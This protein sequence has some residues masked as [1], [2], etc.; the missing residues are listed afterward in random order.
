MTTIYLGQRDGRTPDEDHD[1]HPAPPSS[2]YTAKV[3]TIGHDYGRSLIDTADTS[4]TK[5]PYKSELG[6]G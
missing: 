3:A 6:E 4:I 5:W 2:E 1:L